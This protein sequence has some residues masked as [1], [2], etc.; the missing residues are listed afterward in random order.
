MFPSGYPRVRP[1]LQAAFI[2]GIAAHAFELDDS[3][4]C[5]HSGAVVVP[6]ELAEVPVTGERLVLAVIAGYELGRR[7]Q[8]ALGGYDHVNNAGWHSTGV[9]GTFAA[10]AA[11]GIVLDLNEQQLTSAIGLAGSF[12]GGTWAFMSDD[13]MS[14]RLHVGRA[15]EAG[16]NSALLARAGFTGP[17]DIFSAPWGS[18]LKLYGG[19]AADESELSIGLGD[20]WL[21]ENSSIKPYASCRSTHSAIDALL[22]L[23]KGHRLEP[24]S[25]EQITVHTSALIFDMCG[26]RD[27]S[28]LVAAQLSMPFALAAAMLHDGVALEDITAEGRTDPAIASLM[29]RIHLKVDNKQYGGSAEPFLEV[30]KH[31]CEVGTGDGGGRSASCDRVRAA[32][33]AAR[34][35][36]VA[37]QRIPALTFNGRCAERDSEFVASEDAKYLFKM[38]VE[39]D[40]VGLK[41]RALSP[42]VPG[43]NGDQRRIGLLG[44]GAGSF[45]RFPELRRCGLGD[46]VGVRIALGRVEEI[47]LHRAGR[48]VPADRDVGIVGD[49]VARR[50]NFPTIRSFFCDRRIRRLEFRQLDMVNPHIR[51]RAVE[52]KGGDQARPVEAGAFL[53]QDGDILHD[54]VQME[55][56]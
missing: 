18:F 5:D 20:N 37:K 12:T 25:I 52:A 23:K 29:D 49:T 26:G 48:R 13:T 35:L 42:L 41:V 4:G 16:L 17:A 36:P 27:V 19:P 38:A 9:C 53:R 33:L 34:T 31:P 44:E 40:R 54:G 15:A 6:A 14:K 39:M 8:N 56:A 7:V 28:S 45:Q 24:R 22:L 46:G 30:Q 43:V 3:G 50:E 47:G 1:P 11:A 55:I 21:V 51:G 2:N 10:V 32:S